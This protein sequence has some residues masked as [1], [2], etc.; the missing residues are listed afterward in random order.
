MKLTYVGGGSLRI[1]PDIR[2]LLREV[3]NDR[4]EIALYDVSRERAELMKQL[5][6]QCP[7]YREKPVVVRVG[8]ALEESLAGADFVYFVACPWRAEIL[9]CTNLACMVDGLIGSDNVSL[10]GSLM[11][12]IGIPLVLN[13][14][15]I[16]ERVCPNARL[17]IFAN[18]I[19]LL[20]GAVCRATRIRAVGVC[21]G[22]ANHYFDL[23]NLMGWPGPDYG[24]EVEAAGINHL[25]WILRCR[26]QGQDFYSM[27]NERINKGIDFSWL[28]DKPGQDGLIFFLTQMIKAYRRYGVMLFSSEGDGLSH[29]CF[30]DESVRQSC[31]TML[32]SIVARH[33][34]APNGWQAIRD[35]AQQGIPASLWDAAD[36]P[37]PQ[38][39]TRRSIGPVLIA[40]LSGRS[41]ISGDPVVS[42]P[43]RKAIVGFPEE[44]VMEYSV[45][46]ENGDFVP[47][48]TFTLPPGL[49]GLTWSLVE[50][51]TLVMEGILE[52]D[53]NRFQRGM[54]AYPLLR[55]FDQGDALIRTLLE[56][57][58]PQLPE[59][60]QR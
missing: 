18:P 46:I 41:L 29:L 14:A 5:V 4:D 37:L 33:Q 22:Y 57:A 38:V 36:S 6:R 7:E 10:S 1:L 54:Y 24:F 47:K 40:G 2:L 50:H 35:L 59:F 16:M 27:L 8:D 3:L 48:N 51:Q 45:K 19:A 53:F 9:E 56:I 15:R 34:P 17:I 11:A 49:V 32:K 21:A 28:R 12:A 55:S 60:L 13:V 20:T 39:Y 43:N 25:S 23:P 52:N 30:Y 31:R 26:Y 58:R 42:L 44:A